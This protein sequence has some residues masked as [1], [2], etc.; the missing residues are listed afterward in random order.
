MLPGL[1]PIVNRGVSVHRF[2]PAEMHQ[3]T[4]ASMCTKMLFQ[5]H[6]LALFAECEGQNTA[7]LHPNLSCRVP[8]LAFHSRGQ[9]LEGAGQTSVACSQHSV[10]SRQHLSQLVRLTGLT[11]MPSDFF[12]SAWLQVY[13]AHSLVPINSLL[14]QPCFHMFTLVPF[15]KSRYLCYTTHFASFKS[16]RIQLVLVLRHACI[17][18]QYGYPVQG[19]SSR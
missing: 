10:L 14:V 3:C 18:P 5:C 6:L 16:V 19:Q 12:D 7:G 4:H 15:C 11:G 8:L 9:L 13:A 1:L 2:A 17:S